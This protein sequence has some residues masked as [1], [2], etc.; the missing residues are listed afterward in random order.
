MKFDKEIEQ[1]IKE[2]KIEEKRI[3]EKARSKRKITILTVLLIALVSVSVSLFLNK[4]LAFSFLSFFAVVG[5][6]YLYFYFRN[7]LNIA[8][9]IKKVEENFPDFL[10][11]MA[12][13][14]RA[15][16]TVDRAMIL[17][18]RPEFDPLDKEI[19]NVGK[20]IATGRSIEIALTEMS[21]RIKSEKIEKTVFLIISG[22]KSGGN[23]AVLLEET[24]INLRE[25]GFV[26]KKAS[27]N[28]LM[29]V[30]FI[31]I[32]ACAGAPLLFSLSSLL[33]ETLNGVLSGLPDVGA[34]ASAVA[35]MPFTM[36]KISVSINFIKYFSLVFIISINIL[37]SLIIGLVNK[38]D[39]KEGMKFLAPMVGIAVIIFFAVRFALAEFI[40]GFFG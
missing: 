23:L 36:S 40:A 2:S 28:V 27:S 10:Q 11:L 17:S 12:S 39:E 9:R 34:E 22:L 13:N 25:R 26:E 21:K 30:I 19:L 7:R 31:F 1:K 33:V 32:A 16:M 6:A 38:G 8:T 20:E 37:A 15:G 35:N 5:L 4:T 24:S 3:L 14:L 29:Y 18:A